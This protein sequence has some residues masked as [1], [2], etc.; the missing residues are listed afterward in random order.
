MRTVL[1]VS[2]SVGLLALLLWQGDVDLSAVGGLIGDALRE[3]PAPLLGALLLYG[4]L[5]SLARGKRWQALVRPLGYPI[6]LARSTELFLVGTFYNQILPTGMGGDVPKAL[7]VARDGGELGIGRARAASS[8]LVDRAMGL[9]PLLAVGLLA[10]AAARDRATPAVALLLVGAGVAG[11]LGLA[12]LV[13]V[14]WWLPKLERLPLVGWVLR[15]PPVAKFVASFGAYGGGPLW[16]SAGWGLVFTALLV[17]SN[18]LL[19]R[20][21]GITQAGWLDWLIVV[22][23]VALSILLPSIGGWG[24]REVS[25]VALLGSLSPPVTA[26]AATAVSLLFQS[27]NLLMALVGGLLYL[28]RGDVRVDEETVAARG[29]AAGSDEGGAPR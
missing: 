10:L 24:V 13:R 28:V 20:A 27:L 3:R 18:G 21:V 6:S 17:A 23:L 7:L 12:F 2:V 9:L 15:R 26:D 14:G 16:A 22:P 25:Y 8:V 5:G 4:V 19:G 1:R 11:V 29:E